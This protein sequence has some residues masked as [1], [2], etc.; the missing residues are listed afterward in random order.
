VA[1]DHWS[2]VSFHPGHYNRIPVFQLLRA[3]AR[4][5]VGV[6]RRFLKSIIDRGESVGNDI[7]AFSREPR[8]QDRVDLELVL[9]DLFRRLRTPDAIGFYLDLIRRSPLDVDDSVVE[10]LLGY[11]EQALEPLLQL[12]DELGEEQGADTAFVLAGLRVRDPRVLNLLLERLEFDAADGAFLLG[13]YGD[14]G[15]RSALEKMLAEIPEENAELRREISHA[16]AQLDAPEPSYDAKTFDILA[17]YPEHELPPFEALPE[18]ERIEMFASEDPEIRAEAAHSFFNAEL[19]SNA[20]SALLNLAQ[21]DRDSN[22]RGRAWESLADA[23]SEG[24]SSIRNAMIAALADS[25]RPSEERGGAAVGLYPFADRAEVRPLIEALYEEGGQA[26]AK[27]LEA[28]W[29]SLYDPFAKYFAPH[30]TDPDSAIVRQA[31]RGAGYF[32]LSSHADKIASY[33]QVEDLREDALFAYALAIPGE[34][35]RG[36]ARGMLRKI[37]SITHLTPTEMRV[38][39][40]GIDERLRLHGLKPV[41]DDETAVEQ[42]ELVPQSSAAPAKVGRNDPCPC[43]SGKKFKKCHGQ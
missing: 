11:R 37:D 9:A 28:M 18:V 3:A 41:F 1:S 27:A 5:W 42:A 29:R 17:E 30:L 24:D 31:L 10:A 38:V 40:F 16:M 34:T 36:R 6:D 43:G 32:R 26:R 35:T 33:I 39:M 14:Q 25:S 23:D 12:Y 8:E 21:S 7:L 2:A 13:L 15:A 19:P 22:V 20:R 4:G